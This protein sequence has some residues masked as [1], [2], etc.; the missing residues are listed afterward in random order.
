MNSPLPAGNSSETRAARPPLF[1]GGSEMAAR[2]H[3]YDWSQ[4]ALGPIGTWPHSLRT[5]VDLM[6]GAVQAVYIAWGPD[7]VS[8]YNDGYISIL[9]GKHPGLGLPFAQLFAEIWDEY[10]P[11]VEA[12]L[13]GAGQ[14]HVDRPVA[15][16]G[17]PGRPLSWF[18][19]SWTPLRDDDGVIAGFYCTAIETTGRVLAQKALRD[20]VAA[21]HERASRSESLL[22]RERRV[23][24]LIAT[25]APLASALEELACG[26]EAHFAERGAC[27]ALML[28]DADGAHLRHGAA[29][30]LPEAYS[31]AI[32]GLPVGEDVGSCGTAAFRG[33]RVVTSEIAGDPLWRDYAPLALAHGLRACWS[34]P[35]IGSHKQVLGTFAIYY[36]S[37]GE[38]NA[39]E[40]EAV[41]FLNRTAAIAIER[42]QADAARRASEA[43]LADANHAKDE[44]LAMLGHELRNP[45]SP[46][47]TALQLMRLREPKALVKERAI[48]ESQVR[49][50]IAL[51]DDLL[52]VSRIARGKVELRK[53]PVDIDEII[54]TAME[55]AEPLFEA[56]EQT[57]EVAI[58]DGLVVEG[59]RRRLTQIVT[60]LLTNAAKYSPPRRTIHVSAAENA[61]KAAIRVRDEGFGIEPE[62]LPHIFDLFRQGKQAI[63]RA[64]GGLGL[65]LAIVH[66]LVSLHGGSVEASSAGKDRGSEFIVYFPL[67]AHRSARREDKSAAVRVQPGTRRPLRVLIVD[68]YANAAESLAALL[69]AEGFETR[70]SHDGPAA[71]A[72]AADFRPQVALVDIGLPVMDGY[73]VARRLRESAVPGTLALVAL[74]G[75]GQRSDRQRT[76]EAGFDAHLVKPV[77]A[78][79]IGGL[80]ERIAERVTSLPARDVGSERE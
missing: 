80:I 28:L 23:L 40:I 39:A 3:A 22:A 15:L 42:E 1:A 46:I 10:R 37:P 72:A 47:T 12:T 13:A 66:N 19:F 78:A 35:I 20:S 45:L 30:S 61:G 24:E 73:E 27:A 26:I 41:S 32:D 71:L 5:A 8:L 17:R 56:R 62:L 60:N 4:T 58:K 68:D 48:I 6:L 33:T 63:D 51:V 18:T 67:L 16:A 43:A 59:D 11:M 14:H 76:L 53:T 36:P 77:D 38:P 25:G 79:S 69:A 64:D 44:F 65:G 9:G 55:T 74:T 29:P 7:L 21:A 34:T 2:I 57:V 70:V 52:D 75:Y 54:S 50:V 31:R 49:H